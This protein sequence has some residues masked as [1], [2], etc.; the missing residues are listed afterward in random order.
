MKRAIGVSR[1][2]FTMIKKTP[3]LIILSFC[4]YTLKGQTISD[5]TI[6]LKEVSVVDLYPG[7]ISTVSSPASVC[8]LNRSQLNEQPGTS[9]LH[10]LNSLPGIR[11]E[12]RSPGSYRL[13]IRGSLLRSPF[14][15]RNVKIY[16]DEFPL[17]D[18]GGNT[19]LNLLDAGAIR[20]V[21]I[22]KGPEG[23]MFGANTGG[24]VRF[25]LRESDADSLRLNAGTDVGSFGLYKANLSVDK[26]WKNYSLNIFGARQQCEGYRRNSSLQRNYFQTVGQWNYSST[27]YL[28]LLAFY[29]D[30]QYQTPGGL[31]LKQWRDEPRMARPPTGIFPGAEEQ[32]AGVSNKT[33]YSGISHHIQLSRNFTHVFVVSGTRSD[34][35]NP[36]ITNY[37]TRMEN[38]GSLRTYFELKENRNAVAWNWN[39]GLEAQQTQSD[40]SNYGNYEGQMDTLRA[41]DKLA[42]K[43]IFFFNHFSARIGS[44][45]VLEAAVSLNSYAYQ[46]KKIFPVAESSFH[47]R[48][49]DK[50][51]MPRI[52]ASYRLW[53]SLYWRASASRGYSPPTIA[54]VRPSDNLFYDQLQAE[55]GWN[56]ETG[57]RFKKTGRLEIDLAVFRF[58]LQNT[59]V[60]RVNDRGAEYFIN[61]GATRQQ[62]MEMELLTNLLDDKKSGLIRG[63]NLRN[64]FTY[65]D[66]S[67]ADYQVGSADHSG[68]EL[69]G[70]PRYTFVSG[71]NIRLPENIYLFMQHNYTESI[72]LNDANTVYAPSYDL[73]RLKMGWKFKWR[74]GETELFFG[75]DNLLD[76]RYSLG[77]DLNAAGGRYY[78]P[79]P[80]RNFFT[81]AR[82][83]FH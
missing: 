62:G 83:T 49:L 69:T 45:L 5:S 6:N 79:A 60:R 2:E 19:Y 25:G 35:K 82:V 18:A 8:L 10:S 24:V 7:R 27:N 72:P 40:I 30:L 46:Y 51:W 76:E 16:L 31:T 38:T 41:S 4:V 11:M 39:F 59:I 34:F 15:I 12:E 1:L 23:S 68:N 66:F 64:S 77:N 74:K 29:S 48:R 55:S 21:E 22:L 14:G 20:R 63:I 33:F 75:I 53:K 52:A 26:T 44:R 36:F 56:Y 43:N 67:F 78:N 28:K 61:A 65:Y 9:L 42:A 80:G 37:E 17:T 54:E 57:L 50:E 81:G 3:L 71:I 47:K 58:D 70:V 32:K 73:V 13:S